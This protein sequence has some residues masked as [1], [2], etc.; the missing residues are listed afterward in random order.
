MATQR[1]RWSC[2]PA[3]EKHSA[4]PQAV[5]CNDDCLQE[6]QPAPTEGASA[7]ELG[8]LT[9][10]LVTSTG[11]QVLAAVGLNSGSAHYVYRSDSAFGVYGSIECTNRKDITGWLE[12]VMKESAL[13]AEGKV[14]DEIAHLGARTAANPDGLY[15]VSIRSAPA[16]CPLLHAGAALAR[17]RQSA[18]RCRHERTKD[19]AERHVN[20]WHLVD[21]HGVAH[22]AV[23]GRERDVGDGHYTYAPQA[24]FV[25]QQPIDKCSNQGQV[26]H[27]LEQFVTHH[28]LE[29]QLHVGDHVRAVRSPLR[30]PP[31]STFLVALLC[32]SADRDHGRALVPRCPHVT[33]VHMSLLSAC[34]CCPHL[35]AVRMSLCPSAA[36]QGELRACPAEA[37]NVQ[38]HAHIRTPRRSSGGEGISAGAGGAAPRMSK[39]M[40]VPTAKASD[41]DGVL[42]AAPLVTSFSQSP[43]K[44]S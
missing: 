38:S 21:Q 20:K 35:T 33:A 44:K 3:A 40:R 16:L 11:R 28:A 32:R 1:T 12:M 18:W 37:R 15:Y 42:P 41:A 29:S 31:Y 24:P 34:H 43:W 23:V 2:S 36:E 14:G 5:C 10:H 4:C 26:Q 9:F 7:R 22:L 6:R 27:W 13:L 19:E 30:T 8:D 25:Q 17:V 39:R